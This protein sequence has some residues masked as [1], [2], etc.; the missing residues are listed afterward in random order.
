VTQMI[1]KLALAAVVTIVGA[2]GSAAM[3]APSA[4]DM[5]AGD[6]GSYTYSGGQTANGKFGSGTAFSD[7][8]FFIPTGLRA[9]AI[10]G[11]PNIIA[12]GSP[13]N[14]HD[15]ASDTLSVILN[16]KPGNAFTRITSN[17]LGDYT[18]DGIGNVN[19]TGAL[20]VTN[21]DTAMTLSSP[22]A[23]GGTVPSG[24]QDG[25]FS[26]DTAID[27]PAGWHNIRVEMDGLVSADAFFGSS[28]IQGKDAELGINA[29]AEIPIPAA[30]AVAP[31]AAFLGWRA[32][33]KLG[34]AR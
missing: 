19:A 20:R 12:E 14:A 33:R 18:I 31:I 30:F 2:S 27:L 26:G 10:T 34:A 11:Q 8:F 1:K 24:E 9:Q 22:L 4:W 17:I 6:N 3:A 7:G 16:A 13:G 21:L 32:K 25:I 23:F 5:P 29:T 15:E 28:L